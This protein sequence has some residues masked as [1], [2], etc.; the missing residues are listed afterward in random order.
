MSGS[1][2]SS[3]NPTTGNSSLQ[4]DTVCDDQF[5]KVNGTCYARC[6]S[7]EQSPHDVTV[8]VEIIKIF[9]ASYGMTIGIIVLIISFVRWKTMYVVQL[10]GLMFVHFI[11]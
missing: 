2:N 11:L 3:P 1:G 9:A 5:I 4:E 7:F 6:D 10:T 8:A